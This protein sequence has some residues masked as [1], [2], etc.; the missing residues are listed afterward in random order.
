MK[1][2]A[3]SHED[4]WTDWFSVLREFDPSVTIAKGASQLTDL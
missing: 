4:F 3:Q 1:Q 2:C